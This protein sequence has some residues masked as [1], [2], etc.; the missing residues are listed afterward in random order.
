MLA[1]TTAAAS[2]PPLPYAYWAGT[3]NSLASALASKVT[4]NFGFPPFCFGRPVGHSKPTILLIFEWET[5]SD[6][7]FI[8]QDH[9]LVRPSRQKS[10]EHEPP[11]RQ[12]HSPELGASKLKRNWRETADS[13]KVSKTQQPG[14]RL[15]YSARLLAN[16]Q[17]LAL[18]I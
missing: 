13:A 5:C 18:V 6:E 14:E 17:Q 2:F 9:W 3:A 4:V 8:C 1:L 15:S 7:C 12:S 10:I 11:S 16:E